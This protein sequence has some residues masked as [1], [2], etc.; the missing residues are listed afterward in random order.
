[1]A[2]GC[3]R[4]GGSRRGGGGSLALSLKMFTG[5]DPSSADCFP[6]PPKKRILPA[7]TCSFIL[8]VHADNRI[9][10]IM[11]QLLLR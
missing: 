2:V 10:L 4:E 8:V 3:C 7:F 1:M 5:V 6:P 11:F 9:G